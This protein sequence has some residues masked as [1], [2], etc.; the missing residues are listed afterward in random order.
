MSARDG[1]GAWPELPAGLDV[2]IL[3]DP[4]PDDAPPDRL[5]TLVQAREAAHTLAGLGLAPRLVPFGPDMEAARAALS[6]APPALALNLVESVAGMESMA[7]AAPAM[8]ETLG[9]PRTGSDARA[10][11]A[12]SRKSA[13]KRLLRQSGLTTPDWLCAPA[14]PGDPAP[15]VRPDR[16]FIVKPEFS[17]GSVGIGPD[18]VLRARDAADLARLVAERSAALGRPCLAE[19]FI[20]GREFSVSVLQTPE[21]TRALPPAEMRFSGPDAPD[22]SFLCY[23]AKWD[24]RSAAYEQSNRRFPDD[25]PDLL[26]ALREAAL[27]A[28]RVFGLSGYARFDYRVPREGGAP[29][30]IDVNANPCLARDAG[31]AATAEKAGV[32]Y[33]AL[34]AGICAAGLQA[35][36]KPPEA[37]A[38][39]SGEPG[40]RTNVSPGD[41]EAIRRLVEATGFFNAEEIVIAGDLAEEHLAKGEASGYLFM[42]AVDRSNDR[43]D[44]LAGYA[45]FGPTPGTADSYDLYWIAVDPAR[46]G[47]GLGGAILRRAEA[48]MGSRGARGVY[49]ETSSREQY[50][51]TRGFYAKHGYV[52]RARLEGFYQDCD[53]KM[54]YV[55]RL[56][57]SGHTER[58]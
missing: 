14:R 48:V 34:V 45:C 47:K 41:P 31:L 26:R 16:Q 17:H 19:A 42:F 39:Q 30:C 58:T 3:H 55:K 10:L 21:G 27:S 35:G 44:R 37:P 11:L 52:L 25:E 1:G 56:D 6:A 38:A 40:W 57:A 33:A 29:L 4:V 15:D 22:E 49:V 24:E 28:W 9:I 50:G 46:Q 5:D 12:T 53:D 54:I 18:A 7:F 2:A 8:L 43:V 13:V 36:E 23:A 20:A 51:P 32:G